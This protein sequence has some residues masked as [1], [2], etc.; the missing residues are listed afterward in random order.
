MAQADA[1]PPVLAGVHSKPEITR[2]IA[3]IVLAGRLPR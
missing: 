2:R 1:A 3:S